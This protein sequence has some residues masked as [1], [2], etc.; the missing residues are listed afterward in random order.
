ML[1]KNLKEKLYDYCNYR[2]TMK[3]QLA[4]TENELNEFKVKC[5]QLESELS[6][7]DKRYREEIKSLQENY[8]II[9]NELKKYQTSFEGKNAD[10][11]KLTDE[12]SDLKR[13]LFVYGEFYTKL[14]DSYMQ[15]RNVTTDLND[16]LCT[17]A[18]KY[19]NTGMFLQYDLINSANPLTYLLFMQF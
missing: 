6:Q 4:K 1:E 8:R 14:R 18:L 19:D 16:K 12:N 13:R 7:M 3:S 9:D 5:Q 11:V 2:K 10:M 15:N 17:D